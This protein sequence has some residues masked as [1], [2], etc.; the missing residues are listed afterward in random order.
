MILRN[1]KQVNILMTDIFQKCLIVIQI[2]GR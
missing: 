2:V 1:V